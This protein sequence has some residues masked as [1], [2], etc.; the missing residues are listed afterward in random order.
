MEGPCGSRHRVFRE[1][2]SV[3]L[4]LDHD[5]GRPALR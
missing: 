3:D 2:A 4:D 5:S 1:L